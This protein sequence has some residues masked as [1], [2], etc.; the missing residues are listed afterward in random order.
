MKVYLKSRFDI[1]GEIRFE[2]NT[3]RFRFSVS[4]DNKNSSIIEIIPA[5]NRVE[6]CKEIN[7]QKRNGMILKNIHIKIHLKGGALI[8][9]GFPQIL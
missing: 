8:E 2:S 1:L 6:A 4:D 3:S 7:F 9:T 5:D